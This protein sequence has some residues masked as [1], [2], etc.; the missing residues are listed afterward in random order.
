VGNEYKEDMTHLE[1]DTITLQCQGL[2]QHNGRASVREQ[3]DNL[4]ESM[5]KVVLLQ[6]QLR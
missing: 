5:T 4:E 1:E 3:E 2:S 6:P